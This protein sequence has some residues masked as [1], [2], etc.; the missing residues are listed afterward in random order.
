MGQDILALSLA[1][2]SIGV[3]HTALGPD[4]YLPFVALSKSGGWSRTRTTVV[5][6][7]CG[8]GHVLGSIV[9]GILGIAAGMVVG[10]LES[11]EATRGDIAAWAMLIF[12]LTYLAWS[13]YQLLRDRAHGHSHHHHHHHI[14]DKLEQAKGRKALGGGVFWAIFLVFVLGPCEPLIPLLMYPA[15]EHN[16][17]SVV[18]VAGVF[19]VATLATM[20]TIV[21]VLGEGIERFNIGWLERYGNIFAGSIVT[22]C[23]VAILF[24]GL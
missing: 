8:L 6:L 9:L 23:G 1:A 22:L 13:I 14:D 17:G 16:I 12:G 7:V 18:L 24:L 20:L 10:S 19:S 21:L 15:A 11:F 4:H 2:A 5:T 3:T